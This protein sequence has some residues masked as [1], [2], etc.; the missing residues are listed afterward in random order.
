ME[1]KEYKDLSETQKLIMK[2]RRAD[3]WKYVSYKL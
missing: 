3:S 2:M 1:N